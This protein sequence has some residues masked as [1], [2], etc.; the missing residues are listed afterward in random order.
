MPRELK[1][2]IKTYVEYTENSEPP[3]MYRLWSAIGTIASVLQRKC[4]FDWG[5]L[6]FYPNMYIVLVGPPAARKG[7]AMNQAFPFLE[8]L[9][10]KTAAEAITREALIREL[11][12]AND[13]AITPEG[14]MFLHSSL[15]IWSQELTV[16]LGYQNHQLLSDLTD[17]YDCRNHWTYRTKNMGT[18]EIIG[19]FVNLVGATTPDL[20]RSTMPLDAIGGGLTSRMIFIYE[21]DKGK[22]VAFTGLSKKEKE[23]RIK[24]SRDLSQI[25]MLSGTFRATDKFL[26]AWLK[27]YPEQE[28]NHSFS[29]PRFD[30]YFARRAAHVLK[31][32]IIVNASRTDSMTIT[33]GDLLQAV[34]YIERAEIKM[35]N[36]F[37]GVGKSSHADVM[38]KIMTE[39]GLRSKMLFSEILELHKHDVDKWT[40]EKVMETLVAM[41]FAIAFH[42]P[43]DVL[44]WYKKSYDKQKEV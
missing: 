1:D 43:N 29:D 6:T 12:N 17:W 10:V 21:T 5:E 24:L 14:K 41:K 20:L 26:D 34:E 32:S 35:P 2:W 39:L 27:W 11:K 3:Q 28:E 36:V 23:T 33:E 15:T 31:L 7:T 40:L 9:G 4:R 13:N 44:F 22:L 38:T 8:E 37:S 19:V 25:Q 30:G 18:D 16:F 42:K